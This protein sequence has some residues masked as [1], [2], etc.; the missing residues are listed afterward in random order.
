M[1]RKKIT[2]PPGAEFDAFVN[3]AMKS[4]EV[5]LTERR[6]RLIVVECENDKMLDSLRRLGG[7]IQDD[8]KYTP[9]LD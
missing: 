4:G 9:D 6:D 7:K 5:V 2:V 3:E 8:R 1:I